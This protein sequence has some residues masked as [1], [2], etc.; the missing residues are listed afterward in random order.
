MRTGPDVVVVG[1]GVVG[2]SIAFHLA[3]RGASVTVFDR[4]GIGAGASGVQPGGLRQQWGT[5]VNCTLA[6]ESM[7]FYADIRERLQMRVDPGFRACGYLFLAHSE[8]VLGKL[9]ENVR[10][11][12]SLGV[13]SRTVTPAEIA[14]LVPGLDVTTVAGG[15][16]SADD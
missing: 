10:L 12:N 11:Q 1:A 9:N 15:A 8:D 4:A 13:S 2:L 3:Q 14:E 16:W 5:R 7:D 6:R